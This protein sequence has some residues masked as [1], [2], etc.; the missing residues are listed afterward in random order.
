[1]NVSA[2]RKSTIL[3]MSRN[4]SKLDNSNITANKS[5]AKCEMRNVKY[6]AGYISHFAFKMF[7]NVWM[8]A[9]FVLTSPS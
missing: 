3:L 2:F 4:K 6:F 8:F 5:S 7:L 9:T 1:M